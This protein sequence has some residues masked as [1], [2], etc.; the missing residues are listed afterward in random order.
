MYLCTKQT[1]PLVSEVDPKSLHLPR[2]TVTLHLD[3][4]SSADALFCHYPATGFCSSAVQSPH[5]TA[6]H[7]TADP[8]LSCDPHLG[9]RFLFAISYNRRRPL[10]FDLY[11]F[12]LS[13]FCNFATCS[14]VHFRLRAYCLP[15][16]ATSFSS[17]CGRHFTLSQ[18][19]TSD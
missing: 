17:S 4:F 5:Q 10:P 3:Q 13:S 11:L 1:P 12:L 16:L 8:F 9:C 14:H 7:C 19:Y 18:P 2:C 15:F 6:P